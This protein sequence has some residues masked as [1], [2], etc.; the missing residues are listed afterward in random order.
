MKIITIFMVEKPSLGGLDIRV[1]VDR[2]EFMPTQLERMVAL[3]IAKFVS[4]AIKTAGG[5]DAPKD[6]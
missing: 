1:L 3:Q 6:H 4:A 2:G 5:E